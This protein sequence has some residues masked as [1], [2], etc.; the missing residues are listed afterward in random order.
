MGSYPLPHDLRPLGMPG[1]TQYVSDNATFF[2][3]ALGGQTT[4]SITIPSNA[5]LAGVTF[6]LQAV[7]PDAGANPLGAT[8]TNAGTAVIGG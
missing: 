3:L 6:H 4:W 7:V 8:V 5:G 1:C 2:L